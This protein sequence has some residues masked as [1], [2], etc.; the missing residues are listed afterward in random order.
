[1]VLQQLPRV[2]IRQLRDTREEAV[3]KPLRVL[4]V[5]LQSRGEF[6]HNLRNEMTIIRFKCL[7]LNVFFFV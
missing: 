2:S 1:M 7:I 3:P 4:N 6:L 5:R